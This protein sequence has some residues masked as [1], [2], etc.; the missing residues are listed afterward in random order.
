VQK[1]LFAQWR[2]NFF[3]GL[4]ILLPGIASVVLLVWT[5]RSIANITD[6][7]L[8]FLPSKLTHKNAGEGEM[9]W[10]WSLAA[11]VLAVLLISLAGRLT[12]YYIGKKMVEMLDQGLLRVPLL[13]KIYLTIKQ[14]NEAFTSNKSS[15]KQVVLIE[16]PQPGQRVVGFVTGEQAQAFRQGQQK[17]I[18][19]FVPTTPNPTSGFLVMVP[20]SE[21]TKLDMSVAEG[22]KFIVSLGAIPPEPSLAPRSV[23]RL[24]SE[25]EPTGGTP[26]PLPNLPSPHDGG[27]QAGAIDAA[28]KER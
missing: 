25:K 9:Y 28:A 11:L 23:P 15:F 12:R 10:Y 4:A 14:V 3:T 24:T 22:I 2:A 16:F 6:L 7:L 18:S 20:E 19:V 21:V 26:A 13:N 27:V 5:F 17:T 1:S 8:F